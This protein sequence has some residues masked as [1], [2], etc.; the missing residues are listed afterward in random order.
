MLAAV[1]DRLGSVGKYYPYG[2][3][4][5]GG[6]PP[7]DQVKF[8]TYTRDSGTGLD[9]ADQRYYASTFGRFMTPDPDRTAVVLATQE[10]G[11]GMPT[12]EAIR[13]IRSIRAVCTRLLPESYFETWAIGTKPGSPAVA[14]SLVAR[15][16]GKTPPYQGHVVPRAAI[17]S[18]RRPA[19]RQVLLYGSSG[20]A[21]TGTANE[22]SEILGY[23]Q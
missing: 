1:Q 5:G 17:D 7:N 13:L 20:R 18:C 16:G 9:Y 11:I 12:P 22:T 14:A 6:N 3:E 21:D 23:H 2:E 8:A 4:R 19:R 10:A 15:L